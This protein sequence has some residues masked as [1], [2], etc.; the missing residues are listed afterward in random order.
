MTM[1]GLAK[2]KYIA[3]IASI[4]LL[5]DFTRIPLYFDQGFLSREH[6]HLIPVLL[7]IAFVGSYIGRKIVNHIPTELLRN[8]ILIG[9]IVMSIW[10][11]WQG[12][13]HI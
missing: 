6:L 2:E 10:L 9:I 12:F 11:G 1:F 4:A 5:V 8:I 13:T 3:T 7:I